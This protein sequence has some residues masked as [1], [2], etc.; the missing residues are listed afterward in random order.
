[1]CWWWIITVFGACVYVCGSVLL[2]S[3]VYGLRRLSWWGLGEGSSQAVAL[4]QDTD[5]PAACCSLCRAGRCIGNILS[6]YLVH[7]WV[8]G[9]QYEE[10]V[11]ALGPAI[12][13]GG[14]RPTRLLLVRVGPAG[15]GPCYQTY[16]S[17]VSHV[18]CG[19]ASVGGCS[20]C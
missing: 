19:V 8:C 6:Q 20:R 2:C 15:H 13:W 16:L 9:V 5:P 11:E 4:L 1:M 12:S 18:E 7:V 10:A 17:C 14:R 3:L